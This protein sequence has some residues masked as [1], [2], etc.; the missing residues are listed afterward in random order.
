M[1]IALDLDHG[2]LPDAYGKYANPADCLGW[3]CRR[4]FPFTVEG[5]PAETEALA[6]MFIDWD[7]VPVCG[8]PWIHWCAFVEGPF[9]ETLEI[10]DDISR[11]GCLRL[12]Q[13]YNSAA[14]DEPERGIG[15]VGPC[16]PNADHIYTLKVMALDEC[17]LLPE[18]FWSN[19]LLAACRGHVIDESGRL[20]PSRC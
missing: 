4:S 14:C 18:P 8:F 15:Y 13:G 19:E 20:L 11:T 3:S 17:P 6:I 9:D 10:G 7:S 16:P 1:R 5:I 2:Y 12:H